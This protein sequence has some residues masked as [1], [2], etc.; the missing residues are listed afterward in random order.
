MDDSR[1][2]GQRAR[3]GCCGSYSISNGFPALAASSWLVWVSVIVALC[4]LPSARSELEIDVVDL[5]S[6]TARRRDVAVGDWG[7]V[8]SRSPS[9]QRLVVGSRARHDPE[10][11][12][13]Y[14]ADEPEHQA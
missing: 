2:P 6:A 4:R 14:D 9:I 12:C 11:T 1:V 13:G 3:E 8:D 7:C 5:Y 10:H